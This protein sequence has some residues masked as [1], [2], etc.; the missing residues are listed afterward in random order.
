MI[1]G[2]ADANILLRTWKASGQLPDLKWFLSDAAKQS[3]LFGAVGSE[4]PVSMTVRGSAPTYPRS[5]LAFRTYSDFMQERLG[6]DISKEA[7]FPN[8]WD[9]VHLL[10]AG[11]ALQAHKGEDF[12]GAGLRDAINSVSKG[13]Q[14]FMP[15]SGATWSRASARA[16]MSTMTAR[17]ARST[18][19]P[20]ARRSRPMKSGKR[21]ATRR[22]A[23]TSCRS[24]T[25]RPPRS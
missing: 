14:V 2:G 22:E 24:S 6:M 13:G 15:A 11:L 8:A 12:G 21:S 4:L 19:M 3:A 16:A 23:G 10:A 5:G 17:P 7:Y 18:S 1:S 25:S 9:S 20:T